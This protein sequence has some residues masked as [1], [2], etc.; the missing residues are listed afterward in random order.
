MAKVAVSSDY[1]CW[2]WTA[3]TN[4]DGYGRFRL[5][6]TKVQAHHAAFFLRHGYWPKYVSHS[7]DVPACCNPAHLKESTHR[8][9]V[10]ECWAKGR[11]RTGKYYEQ[12]SA[13]KSMLDSGARNRDI[14]NKLG[15][16]NDTVSRVRH[17]TLYRRE[18]V[19]H[20]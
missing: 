17:G 5:D 10:A 8:E 19:A 15:V 4:Q 13:I 18:R 11:G 14:V 20:V 7:C 2:L 12:L 9:N 1:Q 3:G 6:G 16:P